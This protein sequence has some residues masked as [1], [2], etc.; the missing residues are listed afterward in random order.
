MNG[1]APCIGCFNEGFPDDMSPLFETIENV[2]TLIGINVATAGKI[3]VA[4]TVLGIAAHAIRRGV[5]K[6][7]QRIEEEK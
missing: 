5:S 7:P 2:P 3:A 4:A 6:K 1:G